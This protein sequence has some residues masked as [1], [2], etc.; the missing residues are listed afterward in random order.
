M[1]ECFQNSI[2]DLLGSFGKHYF[3]SK[4]CCDNFWKNYWLLFISTLGHTESPTTV[5]FSSVANGRGDLVLTRVFILL[6]F[7]SFNPSLFLPIYL[8][9]YFPI[10]WNRPRCQYWSSFTFSKILTLPGTISGRQDVG[11]DRSRLTLKG[12]L[13]GHPTSASLH[14]QARRLHLRQHPGHREFRVAP[15]HH[16]KRAGTG[17]ESR[18][19]QKA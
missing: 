8:S 15:V 5:H 7:F 14:L 9:I 6:C 13:T 11:H 18:K 19:S 2:C 16:I 3:L 12:R 17:L 10:I 1:K 4:N